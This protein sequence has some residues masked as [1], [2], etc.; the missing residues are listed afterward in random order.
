MSKLSSF[1]VSGDYAVT[2][3]AIQA[4][5]ELSRETDRQ[6][7]TATPVV[8]VVVLNWNRPEDTRLCVESLQAG[9]Y[10][11]L[12][13]LVVDNGSDVDKY[14]ELCAAVSGVEIV[15]SEDNLGFAAGNNIGIRH[16]LDRDADYVLLVNNDTVVAPDMIG[17]LVEV[18]ERDP[19]FGVAG[20]IIYYMDQPQ[21]VWFAGYRIKGELYVLRRGLR[22]EP[23]LQ[24][25]EDV[26]FVSGC[27]MLLRREMV[28]RVGV[29]SSEYF[30]YYED[31]DL[32][33]RAKRAG[34]RIA[35]VTGASMWHKVSASSGGSESPMK[36]YHQ[37][38][39]SLIFY[40]RYTRGLMF[41]VNMS[42]RLA[43]AVYSL[44]RYV[45]RGTLNPA[46]LKHYLRGVKEG[47]QDAPRSAHR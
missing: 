44:A 41:F 23:P 6:R 20:P 34:W 12:R 4:R 26:D 5:P 3:T 24:P 33:L 40:R 45:V 1:D 14:E 32:C 2:D 31:L 11:E 27:G 22:L 47:V 10:A 35:C 30:M 39:S 17:M 18:M 9:D 29:F 21:E 36:Q 19:T 42:L 37:V 15:R 46:L 8:W 43:H 25:V 16:A 7:L 28:E 13:I 38:R